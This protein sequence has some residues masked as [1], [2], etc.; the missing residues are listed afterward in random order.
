M[1]VSFILYKKVPFE[2]LNAYL[3]TASASEVNYI[4]VTGLKASDLKGDWASWK[5]SPFGKILNY[6]ASKKISLKLP[7]EITGL[8]DMSACFLKCKNL[9]QISEIP[10]SVINMDCCFSSC[11]SLTQAPVIPNSVTYMGGCFSGCTSL[12]QAPVIPNSVTYMNTF[13]S[14]CTSLTTVTLKCSYDYNFQDAFYGCTNLSA[15][16]IKVPAGQLQT[17]K[18]NAS[19][20]RAQS[21]WFVAE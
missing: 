15:G 16:S 19:R 14:G 5:T 9:V 3:S 17:Y 8:T 20:M 10:N 1:K 2:K 21:N 18:D 11:T 13:F 6:N 4:E 12:T 7:K